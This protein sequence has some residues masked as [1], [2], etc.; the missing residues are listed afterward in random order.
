MSKVIFG[1]DGLA[2][3]AVVRTNN[4]LIKRAVTKLAVLPIES[5][6]EGSKPP[7]GEDVKC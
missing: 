3:I 4:G 2:R 7:T 5:S 6:V 1:E